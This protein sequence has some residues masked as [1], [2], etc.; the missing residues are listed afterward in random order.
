MWQQPCDSRR[1]RLGCTLK[2]SK[3]S[4]WWKGLLCTSYLLRI[5]CA[6]MWRFQIRQLASRWICRYGVCS[7]L[8]DQSLRVTFKRR[9]LFTPFS[10]TRTA[11]HGYFFLRSVKCVDSELTRPERTTDPTNGPK[12]YP[13]CQVILFSVSGEHYKLEWNW[14]TTYYCCTGTI[15]VDSPSTCRHSHLRLFWKLSASE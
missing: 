5:K 4:W 13:G 12:S 7:E 8:I 10:R 11:F 14:K 6:I 15:S 2:L 9:K 3:C 1:T